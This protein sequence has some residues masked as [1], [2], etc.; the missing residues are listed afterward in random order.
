MFHVCLYHTVLSVPCILVI[1]CW[2]KA[3]H[4]ALLCE[5]F[6]CVFVTFQYGVPGKVGY[7]FVSIPDINLLL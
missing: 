1:T 5:M 7:I 6:P 4:L 3:E 2:E